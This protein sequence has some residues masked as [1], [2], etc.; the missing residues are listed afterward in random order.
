MK[1][2]QI[3]IT[4]VCLTPTVTWAANLPPIAQ[5]DAAPTEAFVGDTIIF[6]GGSSIDPDGGP[7]P[8]TYLWDFDDGTT[9]TQA[10]PSHLFSIARAY[11]VT[12]TVVTARRKRFRR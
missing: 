1:A 5:A 8:L 7:Q 12:L 11:V 2:L 6:S 3:A 9:S 4:L 10:D